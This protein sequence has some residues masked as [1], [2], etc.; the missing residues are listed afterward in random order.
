M[1]ASPPNPGPGIY[2]EA[3]VLTA[4]DNASYVKFIHAAL[5]Y[6]APSTFYNAVK[7][8]FITGENQYPRL[9][10]KMIRKHFP[11]APPTARGHL[12]RTPSNAPHGESESISALKRHHTRQTRKVHNSAK[13]LKPFSVAGVPRSK[14][15]HLDY[16][17]PLPEV[18]TSGLD[19]FKS[20]VGGVT[21]T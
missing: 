15:L 6:P 5:G 20:V 21:S 12:N 2:I 3:N 1:T 10:T 18:C 19:I 13:P 14:T 11:N 4:Q 9:N 17:G 7:A 8:G 16:T